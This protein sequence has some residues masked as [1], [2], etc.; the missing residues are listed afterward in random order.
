MRVTIAQGTMMIMKAWLK[1]PGNKGKAAFFL[2]L[3]ALL[4]AGF[5]A[6]RL[7]G[8]RLV[9]GV[10]LG[11]QRLPLLLSQ[12]VAQLTDVYALISSGNYFSR[13]SGYYALR[14]NGMIDHAFLAER[15]KTEKE[16][17][18]KRTIVW[19]LSFSGDTAAVLNFY[20]AVYPESDDSLKREIL[21]LMKRLDEAYYLDFAARN[22]VGKTL[23]PE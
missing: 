5:A 8:H 13:L 6:G 9:E 20:A 23:L 17:A 7:L 15:F 14:E 21:K 18:V 19:A 1:I 3:F 4:A 12:P 16:P 10:I 2:L 11:R 22:R